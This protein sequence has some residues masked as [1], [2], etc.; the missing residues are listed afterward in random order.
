MKFF[1]ERFESSKATIMLL[2]ETGEYFVDGVT[3]SF[4]ESVLRQYFG[5][6]LYDGVGVCG[7]AVCRK[8]LTVLPNID[9]GPNWDALRD[10]MDG[11]SLK[12]CW[13]LPVMRHESDEVVG[14]LTVYSSEVKEP[15]RAELEIVE[16][17]KALLSLIMNDY[18]ERYRGER[19]NLQADETL[20]PASLSEREKYL[21]MI[22]RGIDEGQIRPHYQPIMNQ[23]GDV[24]GF[25]V[26]VRWPPP[27]RGIIP[28]NHFIPFA[29]EEGLIDEID[30]YVAEYACREMKRV[31]DETGQQFVLTINVSANHI[32]KRHFTDW[33]ICEAIVGLAHSLGLKV[34]AE[35]VEKLEQL[36]VLHQMDCE[37]YQGYYYQKPIDVGT[38]EDYVTT[39][40]WAK[41]EDLA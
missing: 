37:L 12:S 38:L 26:L 6:E 39:V 4:P 27:E 1:E 28:P 36:N 19:A 9:E 31:M 16:S 34:V 30:Q 15:T 33:K 14:V 10:M 29:E 25:E 23:M 24:Y 41:H 11:L 18:Y 5:T 21:F 20:P 22:R 17:Y 7:N 35:G 13:S 8:E 2:N 3:Y 32:V 40:N